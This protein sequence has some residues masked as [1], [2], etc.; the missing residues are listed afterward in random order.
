M[1][2][3]GGRRSVLCGISVRRSG[4]AA[5][6]SAGPFGRTA[7]TA[8]RQMGSDRGRPSTRCPS[9]L[10]VRGFVAN[11]YNQRWGS[12]E[13]SPRA[14]ALVCITTDVLNQTLD[15]YFSL[16][17]DLALAAG[18]GDEKARAV[19]LLVAEYE[20]RRCGGPTAR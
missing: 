11:H 4:V 19:L 5:A 15:G 20:S 13:L 9:W 7:T 2:S 12:G 18:A 6:A 16:Q 8:R 14:R 10:K 17:I 1:C 3:T